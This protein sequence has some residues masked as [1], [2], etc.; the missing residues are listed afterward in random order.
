MGN[1]GVVVL[2]NSIYVVGGSPACTS[3]T[4]T[5]EAYN[6]D[7]NTWTTKAPLPASSEANA[8]LSAPVFG[9]VNGILYVAGGVD[10]ATGVQSKVLYAYDPGTD[11]WSTKT[12]MPEPIYAGAGAVINGL[13]YVVG[14]VK[15]SLNATSTFAYNPATDSWSTKASM[16]VPRSWVSASVVNNKIYAVGGS[17]DVNSWETTTEV[18]DPATDT[19]TVLS[20]MPTGRQALAT[21]QVNG[22]VY[23]FGGLNASLGAGLAT[24]EAYTPVSAA[25]MINSN[26]LYT[27]T[28]SVT[29]TLIATDPSGVATMMIANNA[30]FTGA[31]E[32]SYATSKSWMLTSGA[33][34][35]TV[36]VKFKDTLGNWSAVYS[37]SLNLDL[38]PTAPTNLEINPPMEKGKLTLIWNKPADADLSHVHIYRS[39]M[40]G[41]PGTLIA[42]G[43][44]SIN[45]TDSGL[46]SQTTYWYTVRAVDTAGQES[47]NTYQVSATT[48]DATA[49]AVVTG[50]TAVNPN[51]GGRLNLSWNASAA[52]DLAYYRIYRSTDGSTYSLAYDNVIGTTKADTQV[53]NGI[54]Y[55]YR[56]SA[57]DTSANES[58]Q[59]SATA[60][61]TPTAIDVTPPAVVSCVG[62]ISQP[63]PRTGDTLVHVWTKPGD[64]DFSALRIYASTSSGQLGSKVYDGGATT[65]TQT[66]LTANASYYFTYRSVDTSGN[67]TS[68]TSQCSITMIDEVAPACPT[69]LTATPVGDTIKLDW[70]RSGSADVS[71]Y[72]LYGDSGTGTINYTT[73]LA[74]IGQDSK[75]A[76]TWTSGTLTPG[77][78]YKYTLRAEDSVIPANTA[79]S[80]GIA[81][82]TIPLPAPVCAASASIKHPQTGKKL[83]GNSVNVMADISGTESAVASVLFQYRVAGT[84]PWLTIPSRMPAKFPNPDSGKPWFVLWDISALADQ[85]Y[86]IRALV[87]CTNTQTDPTPG[88]TTVTV[89]QANADITCNDGT[90]SSGIHLIAP[91]T[92]V[93]G[94]SDSGGTT[95]LSLP[96]NALDSDTTVVITNVAGTPPSG[97]QGVGIYRDISFGNSQHLLGN[98]K[99]AILEVSYQD[100]NND[101]IVDGTGVRAVELQLCDYDGSA[102]T[103]FDSTVDTV[104]KKVRAQ[105]GKF[106]TYGLLVPPVPSGSGWNMLAVPLTPTNPDPASVFA[107]ATQVNSYDPTTRNYPAPSTIQA[108]RAYWVKMNTTGTLSVTGTETPS[109]T[110]SIPVKKGWNLV[111]NPF[112]YKVAIAS[113]KFSGTDFSSA[114]AAGTVLATFYHYNGGA[115]ETTTLQDNGALEA[116]KGYWFLADTDGTLDI[117]ALPLQ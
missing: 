9:V 90:V 73:P 95:T 62:A 40:S 50:L 102:W 72:L 116:W 3:P 43:V 8:S 49:P 29:L 105:T 45:Y 23:A 20:A 13:F 39:T 81:N 71:T 75:T 91:S 61:I 94:D 18:Y 115:Y 64:T 38:P 34:M 58:A 113:L 98:G 60:G 16:H 109:A 44:T 106:S 89:D 46:A 92:T 7:T 67:E 17:S 99:K 19:W 48:L 51:T 70:T 53:T 57:V 63:I 110:V 69:G 32:E 97:F 37:A 36:Y 42:D 104:N 76:F 83:G 35:K 84:V 117:P 30:G 86:D 93:K 79:S 28:S 111:G 52:T 56:I 101:G 22:T 1:F 26:V 96:A 88:Y 21:A 15:N 5:V 33:G 82:A 31:I 66:G 47:T 108:G 55:Y 14:G 78:T 6:P 12:A 74:T 59:S 100:D 80:C 114:E 54:T 103:C 11:S 25:I 41:Q 85:N 24:V 4:R 77:T 68:N 27:T 65:F 2:G 10:V 87:T 107:G 112:R